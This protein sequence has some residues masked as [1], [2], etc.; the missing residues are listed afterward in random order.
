[1]RRYIITGTPGAGKTTIVAE[2]AARGY[3]VVD[4][5]ATDV[6]ARHL[7]DGGDHGSDPNFVDR[8]VALQR[9][10]LDEPAAAT[11]AVQ[12]HDR[13]VLCTL[14][15][16]RYLGQPVSDLLAAEVD[17]V[18]RQRLFEPRVFFVRPIGFVTPTAV[19]R[20]SYELS[21]VFERFH[22]DVYR[23]HGFDLIEIAPGPVAERVAAVEAHVV[24]RSGA[25][26]RS[27]GR[28]ADAPRPRRTRPSWG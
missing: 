13:S 24:D 4:E 27:S 8:V 20:I 2:L 5:A 19:R 6:V 1:M 11:N 16:A 15:L 25:R 22:E 18:I 7:A 23:E 3:S 28:N 26:S 14:A 12:I 17:R 9:R 10:R 21:L